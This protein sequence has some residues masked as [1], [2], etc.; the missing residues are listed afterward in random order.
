[1]R[2]K[3]PKTGRD[4]K[5]E[6]S[7]E[8]DQPIT[9]WVNKKTK[10]EFDG[11]DS[12]ESKHQW[13]LERLGG[14]KNRAKTEYKTCLEAMEEDVAMYSGLFI[15]VKKTFQ[16]A[17]DA[18]LTKMYDMWEK[19][20]EQKPRV[21]EKTKELVDIIGPLEEK[22]EKIDS[23]LTKI[24][25]FKFNQLIDVVQ[26]VSGLYGDNEKMLKFIVEKYK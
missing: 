2:N 4:L 14:M 8:N 19:Y 16:D 22:I 26:R 18:Q 17:I 9:L 10:E 1:M 25:T 3:I 6:Y 15:K 5:M 24:N 23:M 7:E 13:F 21:E 11:I 20:E 12:D